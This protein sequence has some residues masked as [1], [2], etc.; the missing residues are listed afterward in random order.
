MKQMKIKVVS[1][2]KKKKQKQTKQRY[3]KLVPQIKGII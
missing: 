1:K 3:T 2:A